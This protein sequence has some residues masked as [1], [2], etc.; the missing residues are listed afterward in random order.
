MA[1][2]DQFLAAL[3]ASLGPTGSLLALL[4][5]FA[6]DAALFPALPELWIVVTY[7][8]RPGVMDPTVWAVLLLAVAIAG[9]ALGTSALYGPVRR[10]VE[11]VRGAGSQGVVED[12][13]RDVVLPDGPEI[14][15]RPET[16]HCGLHR[17]REDHEAPEGTGP[18]REIVGLVQEHVLPD[19]SESFEGRL[20]EEETVAGVVGE[21]PEGHRPLV[22]IRETKEEPFE[23]S[24]VRRDEACGAAHDRRIRER[25]HNG[26]N[27]VPWGDAVGVDEHEDLAARDPGASVAAFSR[28]SALPLGQYGARGPSDAQGLVRT[29]RIRHDDLGWRDGLG[30]QR[31]EEGRQPLPLV[32]RRHDDRNTGRRRIRD[33]G[34]SL[35]GLDHGP[36]RGDEPLVD[37]F[38]PTGTSLDGILKGGLPRGLRHLVGFP[39]AAE[40]RGCATAHIVRFEQGAVHA[41]PDEFRDRPV[42]RARDGPA[43]GERFQHDEALRLELRCD[44]ERVRR[45]VVLRQVCV[46]DEPREDH[47]PGKAQVPHQIVVLLD[48]RPRADDEELRVRVRFQ[49]FGERLDEGREILLRR[50]AA[51]VEEDVV[52]VQAPLR[53]DPLA[54]V[55]GVE[56]LGVHARGDA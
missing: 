12:G 30:A 35:E 34:T 22:A 20:S 31:V 52:P 53:P 17:N 47:V 29:S 21:P 45:R 19:P 46:R 16:P 8:Y 24:P 55:S 54:R 33:G 2:L 23:R 9:D 27:Q 41:L 4:V 42:V 14:P 43:G 25:K 6:V 40:D 15:V 5:I 13:R 56:P 44:G 48:V 1:S 11:A 50:D 26:R 28:P 49:D 51:D 37:P 7:T 32:P 10:W 39:Q 18:H 38:E 36:S 3:F